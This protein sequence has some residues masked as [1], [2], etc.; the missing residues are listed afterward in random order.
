[1]GEREAEGSAPTNP[2]SLSTAHFQV[3]VHDNGRYIWEKGDNRRLSA[4]S[5]TAAMTEVGSAHRQKWLG[6]FKLS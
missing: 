4:S 5:L 1:M 2:P 6:Q 3:V